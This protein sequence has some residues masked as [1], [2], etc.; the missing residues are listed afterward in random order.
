[1]IYNIRLNRQTYRS[2]LNMIFLLLLFKS[3]SCLGQENNKKPRPAH[4]MSDHS[5]MNKSFGYADS[6]NQGLLTTDTLK[7]SP[8]RQAMMTIG[9]CHVH[10]EYSSPGIRGREVWGGVVA[11]DQPWVTGA[12]MATS[13]QINRPIKINNKIIAAGKYALFTIP[14]KIEWKFIINRNYKQHLTDEYNERLDVLRMKVIPQENNMT[15]R[16]TYTVEK[17][18]EQAGAIT[19]AW[20]KLKITIPFFISR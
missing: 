17:I 15:P 13:L 3:V 20:E 1:M 8:G 16:L 5:M 6:V 11:M 18:N 4:N 14:G 12:H 9:G 7:G 10:I 19:M 2:F